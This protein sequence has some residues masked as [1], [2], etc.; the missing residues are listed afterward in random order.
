MP[1][2]LF[3]TDVRFMRR[4]LTE[5]IRHNIGIFFNELTTKIGVKLLAFIT[6]DILSLSYKIVQWTYMRC[7]F[8]SSL[9]RSLF[10]IYIL[11]VFIIFAS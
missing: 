5:K 11:W 1:D 2:R 10:I 9:Y 4:W 3:Y 6:N 8:A 7:H